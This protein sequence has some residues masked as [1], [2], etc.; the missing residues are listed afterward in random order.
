MRATS[1]EGQRRASGPGEPD[2]AAQVLDFLRWSV[3]TTLFD[4]HYRRGTIPWGELHDGAAFYK[5]DVFK[6]MPVAQF[7][8]GVRDALPEGLY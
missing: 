3:S 8:R 1:L 7:Q 2:L 4:D 6:R 5:P